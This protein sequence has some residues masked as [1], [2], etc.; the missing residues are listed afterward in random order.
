MVAA[1][2]SPDILDP[3]RLDFIIENIFG[4]DHKSSINII[5]KKGNVCIPKLTQPIKYKI[6]RIKKPKI[7]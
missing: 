1:I 7:V 4:E 3:E 5:H 6:K 2:K